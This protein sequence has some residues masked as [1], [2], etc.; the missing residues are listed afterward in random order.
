VNKPP[1]IPPLHPVTPEPDPDA[2][3]SEEEVREGEA[4]RQALENPSLPSPA[5]E[6]AR[7]AALAHSPRPI[8]TTEHQAIVERAL[9][10]APL[11]SSGGVSAKRRSSVVVRVS[12]GVGAALALAASVALVVGTVGERN[13]PA[14]AVSRVATP[15]ET[16]IRS[17]STQPLFDAPFESPEVASAALTSRSRASSGSARIDRIAMARA[18]DFRENRFSRWG[19]R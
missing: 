14:A 12:F 8:D 15:D 3:P 7:A 4:L 16:L 13:E 10:G 9:R 11:G 2:P 1:Q 6:L 18:G 19:A 5:A 17:R